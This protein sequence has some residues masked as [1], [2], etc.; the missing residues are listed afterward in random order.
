VDRRLVT[1]RRLT[2]KE[3]E[4]LPI[5]KLL[6][7]DGLVPLSKA[8]KRFGL[9]TKQIRN[10][11]RKLSDEEQLEQLGVINVREENA[12]YPK[13]F[14]L[15]RKM[16]DLLARFNPDKPETLSL[17]DHDFLNEPEPPEGWYKL[18]EVLY[19]Y[20]LLRTQLEVLKQSRWFRSDY[21]LV[22]L[23]DALTLFEE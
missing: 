4:E 21:N 15:L 19:H 22:H 23:P 9:N 16:T 7:M 14:V 11:T 6:A 20:P 5:E 12:K 1:S 18:E 13:V 3:F 10:A 2:K 17:T 8:C